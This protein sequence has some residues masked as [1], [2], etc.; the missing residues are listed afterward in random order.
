[1]EPFNNTWSIFAY[2]NGVPKYGSWN[3]FIYEAMVMG[4]FANFENPIYPLGFGEMT[5]GYSYICHF[6][7]GGG[8]SGGTY[9]EE[10]YQGHKQ[11]ARNEEEW[12]KTLNWNLIAFQ[13]KMNNKWL[14]GRDLIERAEGPLTAYGQALGNLTP[15]GWLGNVY[16]GVTSGNDIWGNQMNSIDAAL[17]IVYPISIMFPNSIIFRNG[18]D[19]IYP[20][21]LDIFNST[22][23]ERK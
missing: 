19:V 9:N 14:N 3:Y 18:R 23:K 6:G 8:G 13:Y 7:N 4:G 15:V 21:L 11:R 16:S 10:T 2:V 5:V 12:L 17:L 1:M 22:L 20:F